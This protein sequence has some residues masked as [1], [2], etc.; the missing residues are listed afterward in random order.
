MSSEG[1]AFRGFGYPSANGFFVAFLIISS[2][3]ALKSIEGTE[4]YYS[5]GGHDE[6]RNIP[7]CGGMRTRFTH[8]CVS[9]SNRSFA[10]KEEVTTRAT[11]SFGGV[12]LTKV[13]LLLL[14]KPQFVHRF[15]QV[16]RQINNTIGQHRINPTKR[17]K[18]GFSILIIYPI[19]N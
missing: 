11:S 4:F 16:F 1:V 2:I 9:C 10:K 14:F 15:Q 7:P 18:R 19:F 13:E 8:R 12:C 17:T 5:S 6:L 3:L